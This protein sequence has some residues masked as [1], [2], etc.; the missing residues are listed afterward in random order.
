[1]QKCVLFTLLAAAGITLSVPAGTTALLKKFQVD[2]AFTGNSLKVN[3]S[4]G[5][6]EFTIPELKAAPDL[7]NY[8]AGWENAVKLDQFKVLHRKA[9]SL[10]KAKQAAGEWQIYI[11]EMLQPV[12]PTILH[13][14]YDKNNL[15]IAAECSEK[16]WKR[17][18]QIKGLKRADAI[19]SVDSIELLIYPTPASEKYLQLISDVNAQKYD[20]IVNQTTGNENTIWNPDYQVTT[21]KKAASWVICWA[22]PWKMLGIVPET[23]K[24]MAFNAGR[25][26]VSAGNE[27]S[28]LAWNHTAFNE[29][30]RLLKLHLGS[31]KPQSSILAINA[32][33]FAEGKCKAQ[34]LIANPDKNTR[35]AVLAVAVNGKTAQ[36]YDLTMPANNSTA[37]K[38]EL[39]NI[40]PAENKIELDLY[41]ADGKLLTRELVIC[42][43]R[44]M[45]NARLTDQALV[46]AEMLNGTVEVNAPEP[47]K[48][49]LQ[50]EFNS[51]KSSVPAKSG[52]FALD[53]GNFTG[54]GVLKV[55][56]CD[57]KTGQAVRSQQLLLSFEEDPFA[58]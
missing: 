5:I 3:F 15:Y 19:Y 46:K 23:G 14:A 2:Q 57:K 8:P 13:M 16:N 28:S 11:N 10:A 25:N 36:K 31:E 27:C 21:L 41:S 48:M 45:L 6:R 32:P 55:T 35:K 12:E 22:L 34:V 24:V 54:N 20:A 38:I 18:T 4:A 58:E 26:K 49:L 33:F 39:Q 51:Q 42:Q 43:A 30:N 29:R 37:V 1:M 40:K 50:F 7:K 53:L 52:S 44:P 9:V 56:L 17:L 47:E